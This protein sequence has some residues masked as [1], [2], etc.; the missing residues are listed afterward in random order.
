MPDAKPKAKE[1]R[2]IELYYVDVPPQ[3]RY[4]ADKDYVVMRA[5]DIEPDASLTHKPLSIALLNFQ[6]GNLPDGF[7][8][9]LRTAL[10]RGGPVR[11]AMSSLWQRASEKNEVYLKVGIDFFSQVPVKDSNEVALAGPYAVD[12]GIHFVVRD[13]HRAGQFS[14]RHIFED[15]RIGRRLV[16]RVQLTELDGNDKSLVDYLSLLDGTGLESALNLTQWT[17]AITIASKVFDNLA[18]LN[19]DDAVWEES[20]SLA[21]YRAPGQSMLREGIYALVEVE[22]RDVDGDGRV[23]VLD[24]SRLR[25]RDGVLFTVDAQG[26][27]L[28]PVRQNYVILGV[29]STQPHPTPSGLGG[30]DIESVSIPIEA[31]EDVLAPRMEQFAI[32]RY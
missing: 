6:A 9:A 19:E 17:P 32:R 30:S 13:W 11:R 21:T 5:T 3:E 8:P 29:S 12:Y 31:A 15:V 27:L 16:L 18:R 26:Q 2:P 22:Q 1:T 10:A 14:D 25:I 23:D 28:G 4:S 7:A 24:G 20:L